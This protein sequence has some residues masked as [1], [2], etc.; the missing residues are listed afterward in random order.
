MTGDPLETRIAALIAA[1][2]PISVAQYMTLALHDAQSGYYSTRQ[3]FGAAGDF[4]TAPEISQMFGELLGL[5][6]VQVWHDQGQPK[7]GRLVELG[8]GRG[9]MMSDALRAAK[10]APEFLEELDVVLVEASPSLQIIQA[11]KLK[12]SGA[13]IRWT[14]HFDD[15]LTDRPLFLLANEFFDAMPVRQYVKTGRGWCERM[16]VQK[17]GALDFALAPTPTP[18]AAIAASRAGAP[19]GGVY[20]VSAAATAL[21]E[22]VGRVV[23]EKGGGALL[24]DYGY[25]AEPGF[26]E[27]L[28]AVGGHSFADVLA[29][30]GENDLS[31]HVDFAAL[32]EAA[33]HGGSVVYGPRGQGRFLVD[34]G[35]VGRTEQLMKANPKAAQNLFAAVERL[36][37]PAQMGDLFKAMALLPPSAAKPPGFSG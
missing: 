30:P 10:A 31:A 16:V 25:G 7:R 29:D 27:T 35:I 6:C 21:A 12:D 22:A 20:E 32:G 14:P 18:S 36:I 24:M 2:G 8:P 3:P 15:S 33:K 1:Q 23:A 34:L 9:T 11:E 13:R 37:G 28:Q 26:G 19:D 5:W 17:D 4:T